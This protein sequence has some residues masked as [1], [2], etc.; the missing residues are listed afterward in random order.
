MSSG[1]IIIAGIIIPFHS[2]ILLIIVGIHILAGLACIFR[3]NSHAE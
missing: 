2:P 3:N 1:T